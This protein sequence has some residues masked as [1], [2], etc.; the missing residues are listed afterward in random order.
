MVTVSGF[1]TF[2]IIRK[3]M[4]DLYADF[5]LRIKETGVFGTQ[6]T[7]DAPDLFP[8]D[9]LVQI[10]AT[11]TASLHELWEVTEL[12]YAQLDPRTAS[13]SYLEFLHGQ[14]LG[15][16]RASG[17][18]DAEYRAA[19]LAAFSRPARTDIVTVATA[20][21][22]ID[23]A[24]L[25]T[26]TPDA[27]IDGVPVPGNALVVKGCNVDYDAL[28]AD[29]YAY[30]DLGVHHLYGE[31]RAFHAPETGGC[32][33]YRFMEAKAIYV[34]IEVH[35][36]YTDTCGQDPG[37]TVVT[38]VYERLRD[39]YS[40]CGLGIGFNSATAAIAINEI[41]GFVVTEIRV[42]RRAKQLWATD[43]PLTD[44]VQVTQCE[45]LVPW[46][47]AETCGFNAGETWCAPAEGCL[48][49]RPWEH[50][51]FDPQFITVVE[52]TTAGGC[53]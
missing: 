44:A 32:V 12:W 43:C 29:I 31:I 49:I 24:V 47:T 4:A 10:M 50:V 41:P 38:S 37:T 8:A 48:D 39:T 23:C 6:T 34:A 35:G 18:T 33:V 53:I 30:V 16:A 11:T 5:A 14:R 25:L 21:P 9:P 15:I 2:G 36:Y 52:D 1:T 22:D 42:A 46:A 17:Q 40:E 7:A 20:R 19:I 3:R 51:A 13:G 26:S 27:P 28:A 45:T